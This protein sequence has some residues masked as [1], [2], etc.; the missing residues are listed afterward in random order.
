MK[1]DN[2]LATA[3]INSQSKSMQSSPVKSVIGSF[4]ETLMGAIDKVNDQVN[5]ADGKMASLATGKS[6]DIHGTMIAMEKADISIKLLMAVRNKV[7][8]AYQE[9]SRMQI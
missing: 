2:L 9:V 7:M 8:S 3:N 4:S 1:I 5:Q 6:D